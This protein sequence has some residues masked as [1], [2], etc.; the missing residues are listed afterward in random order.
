VGY[1]LDTV[2][3]ERELGAVAELAPGE[4]A[5]QADLSERLAVAYVAAG[6]YRID[7]LIF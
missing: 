3:P 7:E 6:G 2:A 1:M 4:K 5:D